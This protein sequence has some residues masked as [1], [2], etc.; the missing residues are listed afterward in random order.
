MYEYSSKR[1]TTKKNIA[2]LKSPKNMQDHLLGLVQI[3]QNHRKILMRSHG[4]HILPHCYLISCWL[5][6]NEE[7]LV[8]HHLCGHSPVSFCLLS[9]QTHTIS[10]QGQLSECILIECY[11]IAHKYSF[12]FSQTSSPQLPFPP[13]KKIIKPKSNLL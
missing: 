7:S 1:G 13:K 12:L 6:R 2:T 4:R 11:H 10:T 3:I 8:V 9:T 5:T